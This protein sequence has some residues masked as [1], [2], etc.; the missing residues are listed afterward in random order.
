MLQHGHLQLTDKCGLY[1]YVFFFNLVDAAYIQ[2]FY[3]VRN[4]EYILVLNYHFKCAPSTF[5]VNE[6]LLPLYCSMKCTL[7]ILHS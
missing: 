2:L 6:Q 7:Y 3:M 1:M 5:L 4:L